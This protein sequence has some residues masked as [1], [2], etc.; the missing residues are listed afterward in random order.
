VF[1]RLRLAV[2]KAALSQGLIVPDPSHQFLWVTDFPMFTATDGSEPGQE[3]YSGFSATHHPFTAPKTASDVDLLL[4]SPLKA[5]ADHYDLVLNGVELGGGSRRIHNAE[6]QKFVMRDI[7]KINAKRMEDFSHLFLALA[8]GCPPHAGLAIGFDRLIAVMQGRDSVRDV[9]AFP[10][11]KNG[12][13]LMVDSPSKI[14]KLR[15][16]EYHLKFKD[17]R[18]DMVAAEA[19]EVEAQKA[20]SLESLKILLDTI[21]G[22]GTDPSIIREP[23]VGDEPAETATLQ[24]SVKEALSNEYTE[25]N[26][27]SEET[28]SEALEEEVADVEA[29]EPLFKNVPRYTPGELLPYAVMLYHQVGGNFLHETLKGFETLIESLGEDCLGSTKHIKVPT[30]PLELPQNS[31]TERLEKLH[32]QLMKEILKQMHDTEAMH[33]I[34]SCTQTVEDLREQLEDAVEPVKMLQLSLKALEPMLE[35]L[36]TELDKRILDYTTHLEK[37]K[38][39]MPE[40]SSEDQFSDEPPSPSDR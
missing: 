5:I 21:A 4:T 1:G 8:A 18:A 40:P 29:P 36:H 35:T 32:S 17:G 7:L 39:A 28:T 31:S 38:A 25:E 12:T 27:A 19:R 11:D 30:T 9:I 6:I 2:Q 13:D 26:T 15:M 22:S 20:A 23:P 33:K 16:A 34:L 37:E 3:G 10:K 24:V 14:S